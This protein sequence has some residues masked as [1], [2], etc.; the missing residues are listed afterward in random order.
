M[1]LPP[2][3]AYATVAPGRPLLPFGQFTLSPEGGTESE[4]ISLACPLG[5]V[6]NVVRRKGETQAMYLKFMREK[7]YARR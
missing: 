1:H 5:K 4:A 3:V 7:Y 6:P 2:L